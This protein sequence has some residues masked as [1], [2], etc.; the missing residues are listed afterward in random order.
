[1]L[2]VTLGERSIVNDYQA[3]ACI[4]VRLPRGMGAGPDLGTNAA[5]NQFFHEMLRDPMLI[6]LPSPFPA[7]KML[8]STIP[9]GMW[10]ALGNATRGRCCHPSV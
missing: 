8:G 5:A 6:F 10:G 2:H 4:V 1:V 9:Q 7:G 3:S